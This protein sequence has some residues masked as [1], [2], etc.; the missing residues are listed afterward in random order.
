MLRIVHAEPVARGWAAPMMMYGHVFVVCCFVG[1]NKQ[2]PAPVL[3]QLHI[4]WCTASLVLLVVRFG[5]PV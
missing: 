5:L 1:P 4:R 2:L 3:P